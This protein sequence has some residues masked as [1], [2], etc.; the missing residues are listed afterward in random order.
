MWYAYEYCVT[1]RWRKFLL[2]CTFLNVGSLESGY[3]I[4][5][6]LR[7]I[8]MERLFASLFISGHNRRPVTDARVVQLSQLP[9][10]CTTLEDSCL[11]HA[12]ALPTLRFHYI[13]ALFTR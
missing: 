2:F 8:H 10:P 11:V 7:L 1:M 9:Q 4:V 3:V 13:P 5:N 6:T 12:T